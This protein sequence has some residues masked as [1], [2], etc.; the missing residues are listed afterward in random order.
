[1]FKHLLKAGELAILLLLAALNLRFNP[2][3]P[4]SVIAQEVT[5]TKCGCTGTTC[6]S[7]NT[8]GG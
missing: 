1:M 2:F 8:T 6:Y 4:S 7:S 5:G 3:T